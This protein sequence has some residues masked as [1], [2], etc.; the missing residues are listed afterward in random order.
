ML[1]FL[2][3]AW[4]QGGVSTVRGAARDQSQ[5]TIPSALVTLTNSATN[6]R[7]TT[8]TNDAGIFALPGVVPGPYRITMEAPGFED[9]E[10]TLTVSVQHDL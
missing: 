7:R 4:P 5:A 9:F 2:P 1:L 3:A 6:V 10:A 8:R